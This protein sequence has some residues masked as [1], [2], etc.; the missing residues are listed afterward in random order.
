MKVAEDNMISDNRLTEFAD[1]ELV[2]AYCK[3]PAMLSMQAYM[4]VFIP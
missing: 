3:V 2:S 4:G 1:A